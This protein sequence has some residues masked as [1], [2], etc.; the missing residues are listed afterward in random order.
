MSRSFR[1]NKFKERDQKYFVKLKR[2]KKESKYKNN[3][4]YE[5]D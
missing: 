1:D 5:V 4:Y 2:E 3:R